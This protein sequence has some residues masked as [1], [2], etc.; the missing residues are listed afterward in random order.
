MHCLWCTDHRLNLVARD[1]KDVPNINFVIKFIDWITALDRLVSYTAFVR[2]NPDFPKKKK[3]PPPSETRW[4][5]YRDALTALLDQ[6][7]EVD[8]F[9]N[10]NQNRQKWARHIATSKHP[11]GQIKDVFTTFEHP[12]VM[13]HFKFAHFVLDVL[14][15]INTIF[16]AKCG[17]ITDFWD[18]QCPLACF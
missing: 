8:A 5:F 13:A 15:E 9:L 12:L 2:A 16:Q 1:F 4:L 17:F 6:T 18:F 10:T 14:A 11:L 7:E 3:I